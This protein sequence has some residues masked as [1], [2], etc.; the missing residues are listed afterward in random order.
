MNTYLSNKDNVDRSVVDKYNIISIKLF[1]FY[2]LDY[3]LQIVMF[4]S[5]EK[6]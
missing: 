3:Q 6:V 2:S 1:K 5:T 4:E